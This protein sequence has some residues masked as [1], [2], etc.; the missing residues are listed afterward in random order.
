MSSAAANII[1]ILILAIVIF[2]ACRY[3]YK[4]KRKGTHCIGCPMAGNC[5]KAISECANKA[6][7]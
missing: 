7:R 4:E 2:A 5:H 6:K 1:V 3:I